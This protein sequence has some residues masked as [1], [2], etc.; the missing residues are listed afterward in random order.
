M[1]VLVVTE[2]NANGNINQSSDMAILNNGLFFPLHMVLTLP[3]ANRD[4]GKILR[5]MAK[6]A[7]A[8]TVTESV[9]GF[10]GGGAASDVATFGGAKGDGLELF[11]LGGVWYVLRKT[12]VTLS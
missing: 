3:I 12:N 2:Y 7:H 5:I 8:H 10:N 9:H 4:D 6:D 11:A 1:E